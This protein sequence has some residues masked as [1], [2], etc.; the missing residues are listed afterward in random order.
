MGARHADV[1]FQYS[2]KTRGCLT[3]YKQHRNSELVAGYKADAVA[4]LSWFVYIQCCR[5]Y[6]ICL[7]VDLPT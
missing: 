2:V 4:L 3:C 6:T 7:A 1:V 5:V